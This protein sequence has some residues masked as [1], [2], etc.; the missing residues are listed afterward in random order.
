[1]TEIPDK[2]STVSEALESCRLEVVRR[3][4]AKS[5]PRSVSAS[6]T[7]IVENDDGKGWRTER[8]IAAISGLNNLGTL[9]AIRDPAYSGPELLDLNEQLEPLAQKLNS[10]TDLG[11]REHSYFPNLEGVDAI[12]RRYLNPL[13]MH[14]L[15][16]LSDLDMP[17]VPTTSRLS[18][19]L[20]LLIRLSTEIVNTTQMAVAGI[21]AMGS[22]EY[23]DIA[24]RKLTQREMGIVFEMRSGE[25]N[26]RPFPRGDFVPALSFTSF[27]PST[28]IEVKTR[29]PR[30]RQLHQ[31]TL[32]NR[33]ALAFFLSG[34]ELS[35]TGA[36]SSFDIPSWVTSATSLAPFPVSEKLGATPKELTENDFRTVVDLAYKIPEFGAGEGSSREIVLFR[37]LRGC[38][39]HWKESGFLD[40]AIALEAALLNNSTTEL[41]YRFSL[42]GALFL[43]DSRDPKQ[44]YD[45]LKNIYSVRSRLVHGS[46]VNQ[47]HHQAAEKDARELALAVV[48]K[49]VDFGWPDKETLDR[50]AIGSWP[51]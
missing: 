33:I 38:G 37:V 11:T 44:T 41:S 26:V 49:S 34:Y 13:A 16:G 7:L 21:A 12:I 23:R 47:V 39:M 50:V 24:V 3:M 10:E 9:L 35:S 5:L 36:A 8:E 48:R 31:S 51:L 19:E 18:E 29:R 30:D 15:Y 28:L 14:Y 17:D 27:L 40:F 45:Q 1:M 43:R 6:Q 25:W 2:S 32:H 42:Y 20:D 4:V 46:R 22:F